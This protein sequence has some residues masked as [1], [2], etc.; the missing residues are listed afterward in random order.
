L[1]IS[2]SASA[3]VWREKN[4]QARVWPTGASFRNKSGVKSPRK[5]IFSRGD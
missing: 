3:P 4:T 5:I 1:V 2:E